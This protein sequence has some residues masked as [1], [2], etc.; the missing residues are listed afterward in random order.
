MKL[1]VSSLL[2]KNSWELFCFDFDYLASAVIT[3][4]RTNA[5]RLARLLAIRASGKASRL[6]SVVRAPLAAARFRV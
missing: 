4:G 5:M 3:A 2:L 1:I 6:Q